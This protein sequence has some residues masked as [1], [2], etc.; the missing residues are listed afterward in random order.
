MHDREADVAD[1]AIGV[2]LLD[3]LLKGEAGWLVRAGRAS[4]FSVPSRIPSCDLLYR[5]RRSG[6][7]SRSQ[8]PP[9]PG[10]PA[11]NARV[12]PAGQAGQEV[13]RAHPVRCTFG[14]GLVD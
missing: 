5:A 2:A 4:P 11:R 14:F 7:R 10:P 12:D 8:G 13:R 9:A 6:P 3:E 1:D